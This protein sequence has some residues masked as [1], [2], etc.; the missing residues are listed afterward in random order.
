MLTGG[1]NVMV[2]GAIDDETRAD[3]PQG[4]QHVPEWRRYMRG[5]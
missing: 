2:D 3:Q 1:S 5:S 4:A